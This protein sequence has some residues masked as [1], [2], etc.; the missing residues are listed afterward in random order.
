[1]VFGPPD[2]TL[3]NGAGTSLGLLLTAVSISKSA[4][5]IK[6]PNAAGETVNITTFNQNITAT[7]TCRAIADTRAN[8]VTKLLLMPSPGAV[9]LAVTEGSP[10]TWTDTDFSAG[11]SGKPWSVVSA[12]RSPTTGAHVDYELVLEREGA[13]ADA[14]YT[15]V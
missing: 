8:A 10:D 5:R 13:I 6:T 7:C 11:S 1:M 4:Q 12:T 9:V 15:P 3:N 14:G 2:A